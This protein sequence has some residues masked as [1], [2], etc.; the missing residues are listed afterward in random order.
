M[1]KLENE[2]FGIMKAVYMFTYMHTETEETVM[3][4]RRFG[5][6][7]TQILGLINCG[8]GHW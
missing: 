6:I 4:I 7:H 8:G 2:T 1:T 5:K 3:H